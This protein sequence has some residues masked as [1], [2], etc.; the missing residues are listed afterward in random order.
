MVAAFGLAL[1]PATFAAAP[2]HEFTLA[3]GLKVLV[4]EDRRAP[5]A[6]SQV[7]YK[8]GSSYEPSGLTGISHLLEHL[9][10]KGTPTVPQGE[11]SRRIARIGGQE[12]AFTSYDYT[13]YYQNV[14]RDRLE[15]VMEMEA[16]RMVNLTLTEAQVTPER[17]VVLEERSQRIDNDPAAI[18]GEEAQAVRFLNHPYRRPIIGWLHEIEGLDA[19][20]VLAFYRRWYAPNNAVVVVSGDITLDDLRALAE[21]TY[22]RLPKG[23]LPDR[24]QL[25]EPPQRVERRVSLTDARVGQP[26]WTRS[27]LAPSYRSGEVARAYPLQVLAE[28]LGG[29]PTSRLYRRLVVEQPLAVAAAAGYDPTQRGPASFIVYA[30]PRPGV[31]LEQIEDAVEAE[32]AALVRPGSNDPIGEEEVA[33]AKGRM[34]ADAVYARDQYSTASHLIGEALSIGQSLDDVE[35]WPERIAAVDRAQVEAAARAVLRDTGVTALLLADG[36]APPTDGPP[37]DGPPAPA[38]PPPGRG[39]TVIR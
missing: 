4:R 11:F 39:G 32:I 35:A 23:E 1:A 16:D 15:Q 28:L 8:V 19:K 24:P 10:F 36:T 27:W 20:E 30:S 9:M 18:L 34:A 5:V 33:R 25:G 37:T 7:W 21:R 13:A 2:V 31:A 14:A 6:V 26:S 12:N 38:G 29:G 22:G 17:M 3:N